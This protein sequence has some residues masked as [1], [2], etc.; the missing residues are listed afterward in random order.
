[1]NEAKAYS[2]ELGDILRTFDPELMR[3]FIKRNRHLYPQGIADA[4]L[5]NDDWFIRGM[6]AKMVINRTDMSFND[7]KKARVI[8]NKMN[9][10]ESIL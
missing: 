7:Q 9:W 8:L 4:L 5:S 2:K 10:G 6:M 3:E 1:M